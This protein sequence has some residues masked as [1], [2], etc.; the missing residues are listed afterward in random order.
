MY[1]EQ[2]HTKGEEGYDSFC[3]FNATFKLIRISANFEFKLRINTNFKF[4]YR[5][6]KKKLTRS[7]CAFPFNILPTWKLFFRKIL[8]EIV[9]F[10]LL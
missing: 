5:I 1:I 9:N 4:M 3:I 10:W 8:P 6:I 7:F 2:Y